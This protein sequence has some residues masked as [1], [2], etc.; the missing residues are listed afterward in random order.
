MRIVP[1]IACGK[2]KSTEQEFVIQYV[3]NR[4]RSCDGR[5]DGQAAALEA[6]RA[7]REINRV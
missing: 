4:A 6:K 5:L 2:Q 1:N 3:L 7:W